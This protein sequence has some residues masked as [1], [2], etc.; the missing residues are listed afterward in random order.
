MFSWVMGLGYIYVTN[1]PD[2][3]IIITKSRAENQATLLMIS[4]YC[5]SI[6]KKI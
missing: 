1:W 5:L 4:D 6:I 3:G 2:T